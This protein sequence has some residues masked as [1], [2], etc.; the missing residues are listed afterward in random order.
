M[1]TNAIIRIIIWSLVLVILTGILV[2]F[3]AEELYL[4]EYTVSIPEELPQISTEAAVSALPNEETL[5]LDSHQIRELEIEWVAGDILIQ[6]MDVD[7]I[8]ISE[9]DVSDEKYSMVWKIRNEK[10][11]IY[12]CE[13]NIPFGFGIS[14]SSDLSKDLYIYV[15]RD[16]NCDSLEID[17]AAATV[18]INDLTI[19]KMDFDGASGTCEIE[20]CSITDL[21]IDTASGD[22]RFSGS[23]ETLDF[24]AASASFEAEFTNTPSRI[25]MDGMS[26]SLDIALPEDCGFS[27]CVEGLS[28]DLVSD[29]D[30]TWRNDRFVYGDG[31][32]RIDVDGMACD[33]TIRR[34][35][36]TPFCEDPDCT[37][38]E[39]HFHTTIE[40]TYSRD[41]FTKGD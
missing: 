4:N 23:L 39:D 35:A 37:I 22:I 32:C 41:A 11:S 40:E 24:D 2:G 21:D 7:Q 12:F 9:S 13:E 5:T 38:P 18:E 15:P 31:R 3:V 27:V 29:F 20:N 1:K 17:A 30:Y 25:D 14:G 10:L 33:V 36:F 26:G 34:A 28:D 19:Q 16:W 6:P 8:T